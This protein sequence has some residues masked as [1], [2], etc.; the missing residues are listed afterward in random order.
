MRK[1]REVALG[2]CR[3][4]GGSGWQFLGHSDHLTLALLGAGVMKVTRD[5][6]DPWGLAKDP[7]CLCDTSDKMFPA[8]FL[9]CVSLTLLRS[10]KRASEVQ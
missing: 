4:D 5:P 3:A 1:W 2:V 9:L 8:G 7:L 10:L 6:R